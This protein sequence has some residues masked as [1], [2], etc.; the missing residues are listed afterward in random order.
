MNPSQL[1][2]T[3]G[4]LRKAGSVF[5]VLFTQGETTRFSD[6]AYSPERVAALK[7]IVSDI[8]SYYEKEQRRPELLA[9]G[10]D[11]GSL[12]ILMRG[13]HRLVVL[14]HRSDEADFIAKAGGAFL[15][16]Y[17][18]SLAAERFLAADRA[19]PA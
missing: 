11:G 17:F 19:A 15:K 10:F 18:A 7:K 3:L 8:A 5:G 4:A 2:A 13:D 9:F 12:V 1:A 6:L 14:H 16:D